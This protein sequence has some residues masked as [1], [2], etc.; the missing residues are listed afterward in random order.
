M[1]KRIRKNLTPI[2]RAVLRVRK[3][4]LIPTGTKIFKNKKRELNRKWCRRK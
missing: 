2:E 1:R 3:S 4:V